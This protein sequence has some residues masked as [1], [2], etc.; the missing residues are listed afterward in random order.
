MLI[1]TT[2]MRTIRLLSMFEGVHLL[3]LGH[4]HRRR[5][6]ID[7]VS[8]NSMFFRSMACCLACDAGRCT[9]CLSVSYS[10]GALLFFE[11]ILDKF[12]RRPG[13]LIYVT[14]S[15]SGGKPD[16]PFERTNAEFSKPQ[17]MLLRRCMI[18]ADVLY[19]HLLLI[20]NTPFPPAPTSTDQ[21]CMLPTLLLNLL[22]ETPSTENNRWMKFTNGSY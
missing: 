21:R 2:G 1:F 22:R 6:I 4:Y 20:S 13:A 9:V 18:G 10:N 12:L 14:S 19:L 17:L 3:R 15:D 5:G 11:C 7:P 8:S 16:E